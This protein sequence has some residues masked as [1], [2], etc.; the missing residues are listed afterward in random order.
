MTHS[1]K[2]SAHWFAVVATALALSGPMGGVSA[3]GLGLQGTPTAQSSA[4]APRVE[5]SAYP[6]AVLPGAIGNNNILSSTPAPGAVQGDEEVPPGKEVDPKSAPSKRKAATPNEF[7][8]YVLQ[9]T[10]KS[11]PLYGADFFENTQSA[12]VDQSRTPVSDDYILGAGDQL[13]IRIWG[14]T[15]GDTT[16]TIDRNGQISLPRLGNL[17]LAGVRAS[18]AEALVKAMLSRHYKDFEASVTMGKLRRITVFVV[19]QSRSPGSYSLSSQAT[20][21]TGLFASGGPTPNGSIRRVQLKRNGA[22]V[23]EF[24][25]YAFL[26]KGDKTADVK[27]A[28]GD[29]IYFP[30]ASG[31]MAFTGKVNVP[32]IYELKSVTETVG[33]LLSLAG[34]LPV[35][36]DPRRTTLERLQP[37]TDQPRRVEE[38]TLDTQGLKQTL[39]NGDVVSVA[40]IIPE[41]ANAVT[42][43]GNVAQPSR[44]P[45]R[46]GLRLSDLIT[47]KTLLISPESV[48][49]QNEVL[50]DGFERERA[51]RSRTQVPADLAR[52]SQAPVPADPFVA[53]AT[54][55]ATNRTPVVEETLFDR[56][57]NLL[58]EVNLDYAVIER[59]H[60]EDLRVSVIPFN[61]GNVLS[62]ANSPEN[63]ALEPG[64]V[65]TVFS[66]KDI[67]VP[68]AKR[69][70]IVRIDGEV[71]KPGVYPVLPGDTLANILIR[72]GG[73]TPDAYLYGIGVYREEV[74][75]SQR[76]NQEKLMRRLEAEGAAKLAQLSQ[77]LGAASD[78][79]VVQA[80]IQS[81]QQS[82]VQAL[83]SVRSLRPEGRISLGLPSV[84]DNKQL[85]LPDLRLQNGDRIY[86]PAKPDFV[87]VFGAINTESALIYRQGAQVADYLK[88]AGNSA[89]ADSDGIMLIRADGSALSSE[90]FWH[91][92]VL[93]TPAMPGDTIVVPEKLDRE[94]NWS[95]FIRNTK[96]ITQILYQLGLSAAAIKTLRQ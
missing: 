30:S 75:Q 19:G 56:I 82:Q 39:K 69:R 17:S 44:M 52:S 68:L 85:S 11:F 24:D 50:F 36:A 22:V 26:S 79:S 88:L 32:G 96:D 31:Y 84:L 53:S 65:I 89:I 18:Q 40:A 59:I 60:R 29:V 93:S 38:F 1:R 3:Q 34:G 76:Q 61:L 49:K 10:G 6:S 9:V 25:L 73:Y 91:N 12:A 14:S 37:G 95:S 21:T 64:D 80:K 57:G 51:A 66:A 87:Y 48:R 13:Q 47:R 55:A 74:R 27:L 45:W 70:V 4:N 28:D 83:E 81:I 94:S 20:L 42:L 2:I 71:N 23:V 8:K 33:D 63:M 16:V 54:P 77:S 67:R 46:A 7:Q 41:L 35:V 90:S 15:N 58:D 62:D 72:A 5:A 86:V 92:R 43:R 78:A